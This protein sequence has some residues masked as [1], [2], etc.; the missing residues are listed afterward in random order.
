MQV[1]RIAKAKQELK[2]KE[3]YDKYIGIFHAAIQFLKHKK[4]LLYGGLAIDQ[5]MPD[6]QK[7]Y[8]KYNIPDIDVFS[9]SP[10]ELAQ[11]LVGHMISLGFDMAPTTTALHLGTWKVHGEGL[12]IADI[13]YVPPILFKQLKIGNK[14]G[15]LGL[16]LVSLRFLR[17]SLH[18]ML[19]TES[20][21]RWEKTYG[22]MQKFYKVY[23]PTLVRTLPLVKPSQN[24]TDV[25]NAVHAYAEN[26]RAVMLGTPVLSIILEKD[27]TAVHG[28]PYTVA[29][30]QGP[31]SA[32]A[33]AM[34]AAL[35]HIK[36]RISKVYE[37]N[38]AIVFPYYVIVYHGKDPV[39]IFIEASTRCFAYNEYKGM[40]VGTINTILMVYL[41]M[42]LSYERPLKAMQK[43]LDPI[44]NMLSHI[45]L[46]SKSRRKVMSLVAVTCL[47][48]QDG[49]AT[50]KRLRYGKKNNDK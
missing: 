26:M 34:V 44:I 19:A 21:D 47:G 35:S 25:N 11:K 40:L 49:L 43:S 20:V 17:F 48:Q 28:I 39:A 10:K 3:Y 23:P 33:E 29:L 5:Y 41:S 2:D 16:P 8:A 50:M 37:R 42:S 9:T 30:V 31:V 38:E 46:H 32:F 24:T 12:P 36:L 7:I 4:I 1:A 6:D 13:S 27:I 45:E 15:S 22:R 14:M 18:A